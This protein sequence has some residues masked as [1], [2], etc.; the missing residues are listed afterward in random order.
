VLSAGVAPVVASASVPAVTATYTSVLSAAVAPVT[1]AA[2]VPEITATY[3]SVLSATVVPVVATFAVPAVL[4]GS[5]GAGVEVASV[6]PVIAT[7]AVPE[8]TATYASVWTAACNPVTCL[9]SV[10]T[11]T[12]VATVGDQSMGLAWPKKRKK[13]ERRHVGYEQVGLVEAENEPLPPVVEATPIPAAPLPPEP[14]PVDLTPFLAGIADSEQTLKLLDNVQL[15]A[16]QANERI[17]LERELQ[18]LEAIRKAE[19]AEEDEDILLA[20][21][22]LM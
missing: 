20:G 5:V 18:R 21:L 3:T 17:A 8:M 7:F 2:S 4:A 11:I 10:P 14:A 15:A 16:Q 13:G 19:E 9:F 12:A 6:S 1:V 22:A